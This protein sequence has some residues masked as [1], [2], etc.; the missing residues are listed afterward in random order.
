MAKWK[1]NMD[2]INSKVGRSAKLRQRMALEAKRKFE[3]A[4]RCLIKEFDNHLVTKEL[5]SGPEGQNLTDALGGSGN[6][7]SYMGFPSGSDPTA[8]VRQFLI[9]TIRL[10]KGSRVGKLHVNYG[11]NAPDL[12][13]FNVAQMPWESGKNWVQSIESGVS[14]FNYYLAKAAEASRSGSAI[15]IDGKVRARTSS[16]AVKYM[17][18]I[19][20]NFRKRI[21]RK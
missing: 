21:N 4:K 18:E 6:L 1:I 14:G 2:S 10:K 3:R 8:A 5:Q 13:S 16:A 12:S 7:F 15:Q 20:N 11:I 9:S 19:L 17:S